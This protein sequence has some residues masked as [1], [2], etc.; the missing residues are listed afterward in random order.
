MVGCLDG[1]MTCWA[2]LT[3]LKNSLFEVTGCINAR[4]D[5]ILMEFVQLEDLP[6]LQV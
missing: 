2:R 6:S 4:V 5:F 1:W 3:E